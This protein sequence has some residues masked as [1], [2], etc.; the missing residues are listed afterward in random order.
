MKVGDNIVLP[1]DC[2]AT[3]GTIESI[4]SDG[5][6]AVLVAAHDIFGPLN[7]KI[8]VPLAYAKDFPGPPRTLSFSEA[9][10]V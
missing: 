1:Q 2:N 3:C 8:R 5:A 9:V 4:T 7:R 6:I 10:F